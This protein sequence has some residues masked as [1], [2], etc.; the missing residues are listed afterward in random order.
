MSE[1]LPFKKLDVAD[2]FSPERIATFERCSEKNQIVIIKTDGRDFH[3]DAGTM[4][5]IGDVLSDN[6]QPQNPT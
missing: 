5:V 6:V 2:L 4:K 1:K 3:C